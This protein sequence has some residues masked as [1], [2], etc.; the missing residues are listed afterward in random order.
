MRRRITLGCLGL[1]V[2]AA[3]DDE[4]PAS[5][6]P[7]AAPARECPEPATPRPSLAQRLGD[8]VEKAAEACKPA[9]PLAR[10]PLRDA[11]VAGPWKGEYRY[12][13]G[14]PSTAIEVTLRV[15]DL[16]LVGEMSEPNTFGTSAAVRLESTI[17]GDV[18]A[19]GQV[20]FMKTYTSGGSTHSVLYTGTLAQ[21]GQRIEGR[22]RI[23]GSSGPFWLA[24]E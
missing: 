15:R 12:D 7:A 17:V 10:D 22:W 14:R 3:C 9:E 21:G 8:R 2:I 1:L 11:E 20:V 24:R 16:E 18:Y 13:D 6:P 23:A 4:S 19:S 5:D